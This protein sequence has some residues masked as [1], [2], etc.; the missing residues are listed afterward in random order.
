MQ[1]GRIKTLK[2]FLSHFVARPQNE[3]IKLKVDY[4]FQPL[5][6]KPEWNKRF[7]N[8]RTVERFLRILAVL[9]RFLERRGPAG[10]CGALCRQPE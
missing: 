8:R 4:K 5:A 2:P 6:M 10:R 7:E 3:L 1:W 9:K